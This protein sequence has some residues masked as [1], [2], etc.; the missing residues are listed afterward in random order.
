MKVS[1]DFD[2]TLEYKSIQEYAKEL[3][4]RGVEVWIVTSRFSNGEMYKKFFMTTISIENINKEIFEIAELVGIPKHQII[5]TNMVDKW[6]FFSGH[7]DF[8]WHLDD[9]W[10]ENTQILKRTKVK[11]ISAFGSPNWKQKCER[12]L[13]KAL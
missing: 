12:V 2:G 5:F 8:I 6:V 4:T 3:V 7:P 9:D 10:Q 1:F 11:A 13:K